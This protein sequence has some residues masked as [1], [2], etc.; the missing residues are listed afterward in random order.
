MNRL[1]VEG[2]FL[3]V[4]EV[5][6]VEE[7]RAASLAAKQDNLIP[8]LCASDQEEGEEEGGKR[9]KRQG[10]DGNGRNGTKSAPRPYVQQAGG[11]L[12]A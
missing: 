10:R 4:Q 6:V 12:C 7:V 9:N 5:E 2:S 3:Q 1:K 11:R 8:I